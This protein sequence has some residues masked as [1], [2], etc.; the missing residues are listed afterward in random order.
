MGSSILTV[1]FSNPLL[2]LVLAA[3]FVFS[4]TI[5]EFCHALAADR[6]GD[7]TPRSQGRLTLNPLAHLDPWGTAAL[8]LVGFGWAKPVPIDPY[9]LKNPVKETA[10]IALAGPASNFAIAILLSLLFRFGLVPN[11]ELGGALLQ[12]VWINLVLGIFNFVPVAPLDGSKIILAVLP[13]ELAYEYEKFMH[14]FGFP[15]LIALIFPWY[16]GMSPISFLI[17]PVIQFAVQLL[18]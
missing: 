14:Q 3:G 6:L 10:L 15:L 1:F 5:H 17:N 18:F 13:R 11:T 2:G 12:I 8:L 9:N 4:L 16:Q 7:P